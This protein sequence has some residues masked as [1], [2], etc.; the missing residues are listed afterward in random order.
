MLHFAYGANMDRAVMHK[1]A[2]AAEPLGVAALPQHRFIITADGYASVAPARASTVHGVLWRLTPRDRVRLDGWESV[3]C[4]HYRAA[5]LS[6]LHAGVRRPAV[7]YVARRQPVGRARAGYMEL[8]IG[9]ARQWNL[10][11]DY[12]AVLQ[13]WLPQVPR[14]AGHRSL[15]DFAWT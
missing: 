5:T 7:V 3:A 11:P 12:F 8:V 6:V 1:Y 2:P 4:G 14:G 13:R 15:K 9:A 10:P